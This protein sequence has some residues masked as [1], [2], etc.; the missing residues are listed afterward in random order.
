MSATG[1]ESFID[2]F[3]K[4]SAI[5]THDVKFC[6]LTTQKAKKIYKKYA[7]FLPQLSFFT[8]GEIAYSIPYP[9]TEMELIYAVG[10]YLR[11]NTPIFDDSKKLLNA[12]PDT[13]FT[14]IS[15]TSI[16][17]DS[18]ALINEIQEN[19]GSF[20][21]FGATENVF[22]DL[23]FSDDKV[24]LYRRKDKK[25]LQIDNISNILEFTETSFYPKVDKHMATMFQD[26]VGLL[27]VN[28][29]ATEEQKNFI[30]DLGD[31]YREI[32]FGIIKDSELENIHAMT[33]GKTRQLPCFILYNWF[34]YIFFPVQYNLSHVEGLINRVLDGQVELNFPSES[35]PKNQS[36]LLATKVVGMTY[37]SFV[38]DPNYDTVIFYIGEDGTGID[39]ANK[40]AK[41]L[42][43]NNVSGIKVGYILTGLNSCPRLFPRL[44]FEPQVNFFPKINKTENHTHFGSL[45]P[46]GL[47]EGLKRVSSENISLN[48]SIFS[49]SQEIKYLIDL[50][51]EWPDLLQDDQPFAEEFMLHRGR[52]LG[53]GDDL[54]TIITSLED[55]VDNVIA[56]FDDSKFVL[57]E[58]EDDD[59]MKVIKGQQVSDEEKKEHNHKKH[60]HRH[61]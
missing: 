48:N 50:V 61:H 4:L 44:V 59:Y 54:D 8:D 11:K 38:E 37:E 9:T 15:P 45:T 10:I 30:S 20:N 57:K 49:Y 21:V 19:V 34:D 28:E 36:K 40:F 26:F 41:F 42:N 29:T 16:L 25:I 33:N 1:T 60:H 39:F 18:Q 35:I 52:Q 32:T 55:S 17:E 23:G 13:Q 53:L 58:I 47:L 14:I 46:Y 6:V 51:Q 22:K 3:S 12:I 43:N 5:F 27:C 56:G 24:C 7:Q 31:K 2:E